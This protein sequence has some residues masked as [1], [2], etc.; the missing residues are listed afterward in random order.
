MDAHVNEL[1]DLM[2]LGEKLL[3]ACRLSIVINLA[4]TT[5]DIA[6]L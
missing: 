6:V 1:Q 3:Q 4:S 2:M 5:K